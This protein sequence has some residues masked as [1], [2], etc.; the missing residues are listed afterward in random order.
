MARGA[1]LSIGKR[2]PIRR[3]DGIVGEIQGVTCT[4][5]SANPCSGPPNRA[6]KS[7]GEM[8]SRHIWFLNTLVTIRVAHDEGHDGLSVLEHRA[9]VGDSPPLHIH[10]TEDEVFHIL[11]GEF[12]FQL[13]KEERR[14]GAGSVFLAPR[15]CPHT[16]RIESAKGGRFMTVTSQRDFE[17]FVR[18]VGRIAD[19]PELPPPGGPLSAEAM[20]A[21][22]GIAQDFGIE[23]LGLPC[24]CDLAID[25]RAVAS[26]E[27]PL[28]AN[29]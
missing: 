10:Q 1:G 4:T 15:G 13:G 26:I 24:W 29:W 23:L 12:R 17:D 20:S 18:E 8:R 14:C 2:K 27:M 28:L 22:A 5:K 7:E 25:D 21:L 6:E 16:Y 11:E 19:R 9:P 3:R